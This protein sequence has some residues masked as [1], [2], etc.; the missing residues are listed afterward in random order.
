MPGMSRCSHSSPYSSSLGGRLVAFGMYPITGAPH[1]VSDLICRMN[2]TEQWAKPTDLRVGGVIFYFFG[3]VK[4]FK[5][6][7]EETKP[8][9]PYVLY[10]EK[11]EGRAS[12]AAVVTP[13]RLIRPHPMKGSARRSQRPST[14]ALRAAD[15]RGPSAIKIHCYSEGFG[16]QR[17]RR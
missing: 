4:L 6:K 11:E 15:G 17:P 1:R 5:K 13:S 8:W 9:N 10:Y 7:L 2:G 16:R 14:A 12:A 3:R